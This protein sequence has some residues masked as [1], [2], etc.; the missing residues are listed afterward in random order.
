[1]TDLDTLLTRLSTVDKNTSEAEKAEL[2][3]QVLTRLSGER[4]IHYSGGVGVQ[5]IMRE[6]EVLPRHNPVTDLNAVKALE[7]E[8]GLQDVDKWETFN[9]MSGVY[10]VKHCP[11]DADI[12][13]IGVSKT[14]PVAR[15]MAL[16]K[17][18]EAQ[19]E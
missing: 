10:V 13:Y 8:Y 6:G 12:A 2:G 19:E 16:L 11:L 4:H 3:A 18:M 7:R 9:T 1:M 15:C 5:R 17:A 14:E